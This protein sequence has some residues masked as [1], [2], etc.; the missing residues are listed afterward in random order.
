MPEQGPVRQTDADQIV[1]RISLL[2]SQ[3]TNRKSKTSPSLQRTTIPAKV[4]DVQLDTDKPQ[5]SLQEQF[6]SS[7]G[8]SYSDGTVAGRI[9]NNAADN[10]PFA[11]EMNNNWNV[12]KG[13]MVLVRHGQVPGVQGN[14][15]FFNF[16]EPFYSFRCSID[17]DSPLQVNVGFMRGKSGNPSDYINIDATTAIVKS[18][19]ETISVAG[20]GNHFIYYDI[21]ITS[22]STATLASSTT[23]PLTSVEQPVLIAVATVET[24]A[25]ADKITQIKNEQWGTINLPSTV[26]N[27]W[28]IDKASGIL[29]A[30]NDIRLNPNAPSYSKPNVLG[31]LLN[32]PRVYAGQEEQLPEP[33]RDKIK[34]LKR[35]YSWLHNKN[36][37]PKSLLQPQDDGD[38]THTNSGI[39][40]IQL[41]T[42]HETLGKQIQHGRL[43]QDTAGLST[44]QNPLQTGGWYWIDPTLFNALPAG[45]LTKASLLGTLVENKHDSTGHYVLR[46]ATGYASPY[47]TDDG[48][49]VP[50]NPDVPANSVLLDFTITTSDYPGGG[51]SLYNVQ[52]TQET[53]ITDNAGVDIAT[54]DGTNLVYQLEEPIYGNVESNKENYS[55]K[56]NY[57]QTVTNYAG[58]KYGNNDPIFSNLAT[59]FNE[60]ITYSVTLTDINL[61]AIA[62]M[63]TIEAV[64][65]G[66]S[67]NAGAAIQDGVAFDVIVKVVDSAGGQQTFF[68]GV[69]QHKIKVEAYYKTSPNTIIDT[70]EAFIT[71]L[72]GGV[73][74]VDVSFTI[75]IP[76]LN[77][78]DAERICIN[79]GLYFENADFKGGVEKLTNVSG[80]NLLCGTIDG[81]VAV[82]SD[83]TMN[84][85]IAETTGTSETVDGVDVV[86][87][88]VPATGLYTIQVSGADTALYTGQAATIELVDALN[89]PYS[90]ELNDSGIVSTSHAITIE[91]NAGGGTTDGY[92]ISISAIQESIV[93]VGQTLYV[94]ITTATVPDTTIPDDGMFE[95]VA[96]IMYWDDDFEG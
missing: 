74:G 78:T 35:N 67:I 33:D 71:D 48:S 47:A 32:G 38:E 12:T 79:A 31:S 87:L 56:T 51:N 61:T 3:K 5:Y 40:W 24:I 27:Q 34:V 93:I 91:A 60:D 9:W 25:G 50:S 83:I 46:G 2:E 43:D 62:F 19:P 49:N 21:S 7:D 17:I 52:V 59:V 75:N 86:S 55:E 36:Y 81:A 30:R 10:L 95:F 15:W 94:K 22:T 63:P 57:I 70:Q 88:A 39:L 72:G 92:D 76:D 1:S 6:I 45:N 82:T 68:D 85:N 65:E 29:Q 58:A 64:L 53:R 20:A 16:D 42:T 66:V 41:E 14:V 96:G 89:A 4:I 80:F 90:F 54:Y 26:R 13:S 37:I 73:S 44:Y 77:K 18:A 28:T 8:K 23:W 11:F 84:P 69:G